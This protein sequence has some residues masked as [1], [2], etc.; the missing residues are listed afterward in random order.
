MAQE[1]FLWGLELPVCMLI[2]AATFACI[3]MTCAVYTAATV[4]EAR[5]ALSACRESH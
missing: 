2:G 1:H 3:A 5:S 4:G